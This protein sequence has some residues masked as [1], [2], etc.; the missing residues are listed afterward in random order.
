[1]PS[2]H[3]GMCR[4]SKNPV[5]DKTHPAALLFFL[6]AG[7]LIT[8]S[9]CSSIYEYSER[10]VGT[11]INPNL[12]NIFFMPL[13]KLCFYISCPDHLLMSNV[14]ASPAVTKDKDLRVVGTGYVARG[15]QQLQPSRAYFQLQ[16]NIQF[17]L[18]SNGYY[19]CKSSLV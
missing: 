7:V 2:L 13:L 14:K 3:Q 10:F 18:L 17:H 19:I 16:M 12:Q 9:H 8:P 15:P 4:T 6:Q 5:P 1:M 11:R